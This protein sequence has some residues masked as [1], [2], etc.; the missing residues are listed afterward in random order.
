V[1]E[2]MRKLIGPKL[3]RLLDGERETLT[4]LSRLQGVVAI[5]EAHPCLE[6]LRHATVSFCAALERRVSRLGA[7]RSR[8][9]ASLPSLTDGLSAVPGVADRLRLVSRYQRSILI[10]IDGLLAERL[11][12]GLR[13]LL[14][15][16]RGSVASGIR[17]CDD[18][19]AVLDRDREVRRELDA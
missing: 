14:S 5:P 16:A 11:D 17:C 15:E 1:V 2:E 9:E 10:R 18:I 4:A 12:P 13:A 19:I 3:R 6:E 7:R 8:H